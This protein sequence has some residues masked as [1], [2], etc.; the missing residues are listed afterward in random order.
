MAA[1]LLWC[2]AVLGFS[3]LACSMTKHQRDL[4]TGKVSEQKTRIFQI[5][6]WTVLI[7]MAIIVIFWKGASIGLSEW[8]GSLTFAALT[9]GL[10]LTYFPKKLLYLNIIVAIVLF[11]LLCITLFN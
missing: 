2:V 11:I 10:T 6:G 4:F 7:A 5:T 3:S 8:L 9:I 1:W